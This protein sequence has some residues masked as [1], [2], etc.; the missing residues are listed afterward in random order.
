MQD[1][2]YSYSVFL[3]VTYIPV[4]ATVS[5]INVFLS[6][7]ATYSL[8]ALLIHHLLLLYTAAFD[9]FKNYA[10]S[11][12][13]ESLCTCKSISMLIMIWSEPHIA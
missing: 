3:K 2:S 7:E 13:S 11:A 9:I 5:H 6:L 8:C 10:D 4:H 1:V 12:G